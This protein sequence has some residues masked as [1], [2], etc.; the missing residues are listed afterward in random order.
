VSTSSHHVGELETGAAP[1]RARRP[2]GSLSRD[3]ILDAAEAAAQEGFENL[4]LRAVAARLDAAPMALYRHV[5][6]REE[7]V[8]ALLDRVLGRFAPEPPSGDWVEDLRRFARA[9]RRLLDRHPWALAALFSH[10]NPGLNA[11]RIGEV[12]LAILDRAGFT[13][14]RVVATF[15]G[16]I[17]LNYGWSAFAS[18]RDAQPTDAA[19]RVRAA[20]AALPRD[21]YPFT[22]AVAGEMADY[23]SDRHYEL[24]VDQLLAGVRAA[25]RSTA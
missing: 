12:A 7:L 6:N 18:A 19:G 8:N 11:T 14:E 3:L 15:S 4:T 21:E 17:A 1:A 13:D 25:A 22:A 20:L 10:P 5:A 9:H 16:L 23:A 24:V 2:R